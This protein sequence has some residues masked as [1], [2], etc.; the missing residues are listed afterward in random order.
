LQPAH[1]LKDSYEHPTGGYQFLKLFRLGG[2]QNNDSDDTYNDANISLR[3]TSINTGRAGQV[4]E[5]A[6]AVHEEDKEDCDNDWIKLDAFLL[7]PEI[8]DKIPSSKEAQETPL[9]L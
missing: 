3:K 8:L 2:H 9:S 1:D 4:R 6:T 7:S 5:S